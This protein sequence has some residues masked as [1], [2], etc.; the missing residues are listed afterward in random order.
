MEEIIKISFKK[1]G[2]SVLTDA[3]LIKG[4]LS[5][6]EIIGAFGLG[7]ALQLIDDLQDVKQTKGQKFNYIYIF[8]E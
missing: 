5:L 4:T 7:I 6:D 2:L 3:Y 8:S 1:G